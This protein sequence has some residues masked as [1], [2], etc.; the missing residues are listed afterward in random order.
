MQHFDI[1]ETSHWIV[2]WHEE[3]DRKQPGWSLLT[4]QITHNDAVHSAHNDCGTR[5]VWTQA[6]YR[7]VPSRW[8]HRLSEWTLWG[9]TFLCLLTVSLTHLVSSQAW[10]DGRSL[11]LHLHQGSVSVHWMRADPELTAGGEPRLQLS[12]CSTEHGV[13]EEGALQGQGEVPLE[14]CQS[15]GGCGLHLHQ[16]QQHPLGV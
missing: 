16:S 4:F 2:F 11:P 6:R 5:W 13:S 3:S 15:G 8:H 7:G 9:V 12:T 14:A 1:Y 10:N